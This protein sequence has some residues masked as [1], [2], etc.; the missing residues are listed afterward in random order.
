L[1]YVNFPPPGV[2]SIPVINF[3][4]IYGDFQ[5]NGVVCF[6]LVLPHPF[7]YT[8]GKPALSLQGES[9]KGEAHLR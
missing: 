3:K 1:F 8:Q 7:D 2:F 9:I 5:S 6:V 4:P